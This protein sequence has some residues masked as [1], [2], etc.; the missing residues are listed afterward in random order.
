[1]DDTA[2]GILAELEWRGMVHQVTSP[3][4]GARLAAEPLVVYHGIDATADSLHV[5]HLV[6]VLALRRLQRAGHRPLVIIGGGTTLI[7][8]PSG[9]DAERP[10]R[11][12]EEIRANAAALRRQLERFLEFGSG[13]TDAVLL[14]NADWLCSLSLTDFLRDV[15]KHFT[16]NVMI[17]KESVKARLEAREQGISYTEFS[18]MLLQAYDFLHLHDTFD[19]RL[20]VG[21]SDQWGNIVAGVD[22]VRRTRGA[23]VFGLT[24]P[25]LTKAD[26]SKF[27]KSEQGNVWLD[28]ARTS[29]Y[30]FFQYWVR[31]DDRDAGRYLRLFTDLSREEVERLE[32]AAAARP[33]AREAQ[34][35]LAR[36]VTAAVHGREAAE[37]AARASAALFGGELEGLSAAALAQVFAEAP[38]TTLP[39]SDL[40]G[41]GLLVEDLL[42]RAAVHPS[43]SAA[44]RE[45][46]Q[47]GVYLNNR[48]ETDGTRRLGPDVLLAGSV[49]VV[50]RGKKNYHLVRFAE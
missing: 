47:G 23:E 11:T 12:R 42:V 41:E 3:D 2:A 19:C 36:E 24:W 50:R 18:Y 15:G 6:G 30:E 4:L 39:S 5:G 10:M 29:P 8:D 17:A 43:R 35:A 40:E 45:L 32:A 46:A 25:L 31:T 16:V 33:E 7:G 37:E 14:D 49:L 9:R 13:P 22:L 28:A 44:R 26:G 1:M 38:A 27:G 20:Q 21:G 48:R 34:L